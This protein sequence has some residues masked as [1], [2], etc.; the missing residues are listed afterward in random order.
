MSIGI[1]YESK[2]WSNIRIE[3]LLR[4]SVKEVESINIENFSDSEN[5]LKIEH[6]LYVNRVFPSADMRGNM[7]SIGHTEKFLL[8]LNKR[9]IPIINSF[10]AF[11]YDCSKLRAYEILQKFNY[12]IPEYVYINSGE[13]IPLKKDWDDT[14]VVL[15]KDCGGRSFELKILENWKSLEKIKEKMHKD[16][17]IVQE[18]I[19]PDYGFTTRVEVIDGQV[20]A[21]LKRFIGEGGISSYSTSSRY[22]I[23][24]NCPKEILDD[25]IKILKILEIEMGSLDFIQTKN[26]DYYIID[27]NATSNFTHDYIPLL[28]FDPIKKM[29]D[30]IL[31][32]YKSLGR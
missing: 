30:Y 3:E 7:N 31:K 17:W 4:Q 28:G 11:V 16:K 5:E 29:T 20:M 24:K 9:E 26:G 12:N 25:S 32:K 23:Y 13:K 27:V 22:E 10:N 2:E 8:E 18:Y 21:V 14:Q 1:L 15:K 19:H 6:S